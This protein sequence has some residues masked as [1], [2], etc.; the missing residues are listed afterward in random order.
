MKKL[1]LSKPCA[2]AALMDDKVISSY[3]HFNSLAAELQLNILCPEVV[4][5]GSNGGALPAK[6]KPLFANYPEWYVEDIAEFL[7][8]ALQHLPQTVARSMDHVVMTW[9]LT[10]VCSAHCFNNPYLVAKLVE[11]LFMMNPGV[12]V[13]S[14]Y[15]I[16][17]RLA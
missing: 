5:G 9:L 6:V 13:S 11:V 14:L 16:N 8:L 12:Q 15:S 7:L 10:L 3:M 1:L 2:E 4:Y 17:D